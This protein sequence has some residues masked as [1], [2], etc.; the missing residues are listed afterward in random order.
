MPCSNTTPSTP[1][2]LRTCIEA[3]GFT[4]VSEES[5]RQIYRYQQFTLI[6][7]T[8]TLKVECYY[9]SVH[10]QFSYYFVGIILNCADLTMH[11]RRNGVIV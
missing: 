3:L 1:A 6:L 8:Q 5:T 7:D 9:G 10:T 4:L 11:L 2:T